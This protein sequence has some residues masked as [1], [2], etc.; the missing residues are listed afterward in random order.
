MTENRKA[1]GKNNTEND[2]SIYWMGTKVMPCPACGIA[3]TNVDDCG[4]FGDP[5]CPA[6]GIGIAEYERRFSRDK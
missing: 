4:H 3:V 6:F 1:N 2:G 5:E